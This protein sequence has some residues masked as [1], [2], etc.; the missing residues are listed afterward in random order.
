MNIRKLNNVILS[1]Y[2]VVILLCLFNVGTIGTYVWVSHGA[3]INGCDEVNVDQWRKVAI[4]YGYP[5]DFVQVVGNAT[6]DAILVFMPTHC[7]AMNHN[8]YIVFTFALVII[9]PLFML[10]V[11]RSS[12]Q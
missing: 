2:L 9:W 4:D 6:V 3:F 10:V 5:D 11:W 7:Y 12:E 1:V 8:I